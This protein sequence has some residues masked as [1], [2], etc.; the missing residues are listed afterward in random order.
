MFSKKDEIKNDSCKFV[1]FFLI[2]EILIYTF[3]ILRS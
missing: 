1:K 3:K 2:G